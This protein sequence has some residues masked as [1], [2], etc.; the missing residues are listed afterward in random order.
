M[1]HHSA[2]YH[3]KFLK[4]LGV[5][6]LLAFVGAGVGTYFFFWHPE[7]PVPRISEGTPTPTL[8][9][10]EDGPEEETRSPAAGVDLDRLFREAGARSAEDPLLERFPGEAQE[11]PLRISFEPREV[12]EAQGPGFSC[13]FCLR[14]GA[15]ELLQY[16]FSGDGEFAGLA[17]GMERSAVRRAL[18]AT[19]EGLGPFD[20]FPR[21]EGTDHGVLCL[22]DGEGDD[23]VLRARAFGETRFGSFGPRFLEARAEARGVPGTLTGTRVNLRREP[24]TKSRVVTNLTGS[25]GL[26][27]FRSSPEHYDTRLLRA[28]SVSFLGKSY[29]LRKGTLVRVV[30]SEAEGRV[31]VIFRR[32]LS[33]YVERDAVASGPEAVWHYV[34][35]ASGDAG[36]VRGDFLSMVRP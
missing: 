10:T 6:I 8:R 35:T 15:R 16:E 33:A 13:V 24:T 27:V 29:D 7:R 4:M 2:H 18:G 32:D 34:R 21:G 31:P 23:A 9:G 17:V 20:F 11:A 3:Y 1:K 5:G 19:P 22:Y 25:E 12:R 28:V 26:T 14:G 30:G 36:W